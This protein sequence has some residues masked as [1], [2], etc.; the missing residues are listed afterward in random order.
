MSRS[1]QHGAGPQ[2]GPGL[3]TAAFRRIVP[4]GGRPIRTTTAAQTQQQAECG[5][6]ETRAGPFFLFSLFYLSLFWAISSADVHHHARTKRPFGRSFRL[7]IAFC[8]AVLVISLNVTLDIFSLSS[9]RMYAK[10][11]AIASPSRSGSVAI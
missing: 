6:A 11:Q 1:F 10:C 8:T 2:P 4:G 7:F 5:T 9:D 3:E